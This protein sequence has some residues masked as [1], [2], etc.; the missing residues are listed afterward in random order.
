[1]LHRLH[2][3]EP[4]SLVGKGPCVGVHTLDEATPVGAI[5]KR[6]RGLNEDR[7]EVF[8]VL[9]SIR[10]AGLKAPGVVARQ[11]EGKLWELKVS[12]SRVFYVVIR[13]PEMVLLHAYRKQSQKAPPRE[14]KVA[15]KRMKEVLDESED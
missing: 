7:A 14:L 9:A 8:D 11:L 15:T 4:I 1:L 12:K 3:Q 2:A 6:L 5:A 13:G 10:S